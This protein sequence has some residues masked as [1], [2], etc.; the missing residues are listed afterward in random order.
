MKR[1]LLPI[2]LLACTAA[3]AQLVRDTAKAIND[4]SM[5]GT[6]CGQ[7]KTVYFV[8][9][10]DTGDKGKAL[11]CNLTTHVWEACDVGSGGGGTPGGSTTQV[12]FNNAGAFG[13]D[14]GMTYVAGTDSLTVAGEITTPSQRLSSTVGRRTFGTALPG[15]CTPGDEFV[16]TDGDAGNN[17]D[18]SSGC[19]LAQCIATNTWEYLPTATTGYVS[20]SMIFATP[21]RCAE[22]DGDGMLS[23][24]AGL[25]GTGDITSVF[26]AASGAV[27][28][29]SLAA[30]DSIDMS[31]IDANAAGEGL[32]LPR[33]A[34]CAGSGQAEGALCYQ[35]GTD[36]LCVRDGGAAW[37]C[38]AA[39]GAT[40]PAG[41]TGNPQ[42]R[43]P[44]GTFAA[45]TEIHCCDFDDDADKD[46]ADINKCIA[47]CPAGGCI[48]TLCADTFT[49]DADGNGLG[50]TD[51]AA[52]C[53]SDPHVCIP[54][55]DVWL[56]GSGKGLTIL[57]KTTTNQNQPFIQ[58][59]D[60]T[61][62]VVSAARLSNVKVSDLTIDGPGTECAGGGSSAA[63]VLAL[64]TDY[65]TVAG[66]EVRETA[67]AGTHATRASYVREQSNDYWH[68]GNYDV[69]GAGTGTCA[70]PVNQP[71]SYNYTNFGRVN[72]GHVMQDVICDGAGGPGIQ[73]RVDF[74]ASTMAGSSDP[75]PDDPF[76]MDSTHEWVA[77]T[78]TLP[79]GASDV[80][81]TGIVA[82][83]YALPIATGSVTVEIYDT[84]G[85]V[86]TSL[87]AGGYQSV[88]V[89][90]L[91]RGNCGRVWFK[92]D[93]VENTAFPSPM[94][95]SAGTYAAVFKY[96]TADGNVKFCRNDSGTSSYSGGGFFSCD[97]TSC[98]W[99][100]ETNDDAGLVILNGYHEDISIDNV[101]LRDIT[102]SDRGSSGAMTVAG[103]DGMTVKGLV[104]DNAETLS[105][106]ITLYSRNISV[107]GA[108]FTRD[109]FSGIG[110]DVANSSRLEVGPSVDNFLLAD[111]TIQ[112]S[113]ADCIRVYGQ[114][115]GPRFVGNTVAD[116]GSN[117]W[118]IDGGADGV[119]ISDSLITDSFAEA[120]LFS[121]QTANDGVDG[122]TDN[123]LIS[124]NEILRPGISAI[125]HSGALL[126][127]LT[128][129]GNKFTDCAAR[130]VHLNMAGGADSGPFTFSGN[131]SFG[132]ATNG[133]AARAYDIQ[134]D[135]DGVSVI[136][137]QFFSRGGAEQHY[138]YF[139]T[140]A[141]ASGWYF[142]GL[143]GNGAVTSNPWRFPN[144]GNITDMMIVGVS[145]PLDVSDKVTMR[146]DLDGRLATGNGTGTTDDAFVVVKRSS[147]TGS[148]T[149]GRPCYDQTADDFCIHDGTAF[150]CVDLA[151]GGGG[152]PVNATY[153]T[154]TADA[155]LSAE[156][157]LSALS[158]GMV[159]VTTTTGVLSTG[160]A[161]TDYTSPS[162]TETMTNKTISGGD[163]G[164]GTTRASGGNVI[165]S[166]TANGDSGNECN[167]QTD[168]KQGELCV[169]E[170]DGQIWV[171]IPSAGDCDTG[172]EWK[173][174]DSTGGS[175]AGKLVDARI[176]MPNV[177]TF[178]GYG[179]A[180]ASGTVSSF[181][182]ITD[183]S[184]CTLDILVQDGSVDDLA[185]TD[186]VCGTTL[187]TC[188]IDTA[189]DDY[190]STTTF[191]ISISAC[192][193]GLVSVWAY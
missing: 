89:A 162:S 24:A 139:Q 118:M 185:G 30:T 84:S 66:I 179:R 190:T 159:K 52:A 80:Y 77:Q 107:S 189:A 73:T 3:Q 128:V 7:S 45:T 168:G 93:T 125:T 175:S 41:A 37:D 51:V 23:V 142:S 82:S 160:A 182:C 123:A 70:T 130:C 92:F 69:D 54:R 78:F 12:Q 65:V 109:D 47:A 151:G 10:E 174:V 110:G 53:T 143:R 115:L 49:L 5:L 131:A 105:V 152:A 144:I 124:G 58:I 146:L 35:T 39:G 167:T 154:Q 75:W 9:G 4:Y 38:L 170:D 59:N 173:R 150:D 71:C 155:T 94:T 18:S 98:T 2:A 180:T 134:G 6:A 76:T 42:Y 153:I 176:E 44:T 63:G 149:E 171:C 81:A 112:G 116:C 90:D 43:S 60:G 14:A 181:S 22:F 113:V 120:I 95:I 67:H 191:D 87:V 184:T 106:G 138:A 21:S 133:T 126:R 169:E 101:Q 28:D 104:A 192:G 83:M 36:Q 79:G 55:S 158:T 85:G 48:V 193:A 157:A 56:R 46:D 27:N 145:P 1:L 137:D 16:D 11:C 50:G 188:S 8:N 34:T 121:G 57:N 141:D 117:A 103:V 32:V 15:T 147:C 68:V 19:H 40:S 119:Q 99:A 111:S 122:M 25:C 127:G 165:Q 72:K 96:T 62:L 20:P 166:R 64:D 31:A 108:T 100:A 177:A 97:G 140:A 163:S 102:G 61:T 172:G 114:A 17:C 148:D 156:Q 136:G 29:V 33:T 91:P 13:G 129:S 178:A 88:P 187:T 183:S 161:G 186:C 132:W 74:G 86:P 26:N 135:I 164:T